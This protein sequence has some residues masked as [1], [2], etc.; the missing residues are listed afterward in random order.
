[1]SRA[2]VGINKAGVVRA[3]F[4]IDSKADES[5]AKHFA[6]KWLMDGRSVRACSAEHAN[7]IMC[8]P[9]RDEPE[10]K[11]APGSLKVVVTDDDL[12]RMMA[13]VFKC[14]KAITDLHGQ[15][16]LRTGVAGMMPCPACGTGKLTYRIASLNGHIAA[17]CSTPGCV[18]WME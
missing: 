8:E 18:Q 1:M 2:I 11:S 16:T 6:W 10:A 5:E 15:A 17:E 9:W 13:L 3:L 12:A 14:R 4:T 7:A